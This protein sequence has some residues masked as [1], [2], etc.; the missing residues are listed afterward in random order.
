SPF[1]PGTVP[2]TAAL[3]M[4]MLRAALV[5]QSHCEVDD[6]E[7]RRGGVSYTIETVSDYRVRFPEAR[8][9]YL[10]GADHVSQLHKWRDANKLAEYV[11]FV[12]VP[13][14]GEHEVPLPAP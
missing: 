9:F 1:K 4:R 2:V 13:R 3:R 10:I 6:Q 7:A 14:P 8:L 5:G 11:E 12:V